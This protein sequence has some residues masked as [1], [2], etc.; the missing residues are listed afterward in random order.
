MKAA[1]TRAVAG[2]YGRALLQVALEQKADLQ[3]IARELAELGALIEGH[4]DL[5]RILASPAVAPARKVGLVEKLLEGAG[6]SRP[7]GNLL[8]VMAAKDRIPLLR[9]VEEAYREA[10]DEHEQVETAEV[11]TAHPLT[12]AQQEKLASELAALSG[13]RIRLNFT[14]DP[15]LLGGLVV[16]IGNRIYDASIVT[17]LRQFKQR[18]LSTY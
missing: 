6:V 10:L 15:A 12:E 17:Q 7:T 18:V 16:R 4:A 13:K 2:R 3:R 14:T 8:R 11:S 9:L 5:D 1:G